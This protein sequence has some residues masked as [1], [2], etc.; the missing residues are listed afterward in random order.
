[1]EGQGDHGD[2]RRGHDERACPLHQGGGSGAARAQCDDEGRHPMTRR[3]FITLLGGAA[4]WPLAARAQQTGK[5]PTVGV[6]GT[7]TPSIM[8]QWAAA[9]VGRLRALG[10]LEG[11]TC[12]IEYGWAGR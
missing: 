12:K 6:L 1:M 11:R 2:Q 3:E 7:T 8:S 4:A 5:L 10:W 9:F